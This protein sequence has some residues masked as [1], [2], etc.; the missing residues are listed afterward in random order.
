MRVLID[1]RPGSELDVVVRG[2]D[3]EYVSQYGDYESSVHTQDS[4]AQFRYTLSDATSGRSYYQYHRYRH[5][6]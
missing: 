2:R 6:H 5:A 1:Y 3:R 4:D